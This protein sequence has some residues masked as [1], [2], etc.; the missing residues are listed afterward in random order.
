MTGNIACCIHIVLTFNESF[1]I[2]DVCKKSVRLQQ[3]SLLATD[4]VLK[5]RQYQ[6]KKLVFS[7]LY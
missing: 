3:T 4:T 1:D 5:K 7:Q 6:N 2:T